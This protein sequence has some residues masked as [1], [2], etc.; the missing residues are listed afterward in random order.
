M[1]CLRAIK[2]FYLPDGNDMDADLPQSLD[3]TFAAA[4]GSPGGT[5]AKP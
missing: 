3:K 5:P 1:E 2:A 4:L